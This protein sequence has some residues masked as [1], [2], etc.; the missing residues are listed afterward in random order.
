MFNGRGEEIQLISSGQLKT[1]K[2]FLLFFMAIFSL[3][4]KAQAPDLS[5]AE[6]SAKENH[7]NI[8]LLFSGSDWCIPCI[9]MEKEIFEK[10]S[11]ASYSKEHLILLHADFPRLKKHQLPKDQVKKNEELA[12][13]YN[14]GGAF[15]Y[16]VLLNADG[17]VLKEWDGIV[18][19]SPE[20]FI[21]Q[22][23]SAT[24]ASN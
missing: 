15:P 4:A 3:I 2:F 1:M 10:E 22:I 17:K 18:A 12:E 20:D 7:K 9:K 8:L 19:S 24:G 6:D 16:T 14:K 13:K 23:Q 5:A 21:K 11:F